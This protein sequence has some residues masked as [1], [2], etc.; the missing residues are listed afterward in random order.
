MNIFWLV[1]LFTTSILKLSTDLSKNNVNRVFSKRMKYFS[2]IISLF[3]LVA[4]SGLRS[5]IG[6]TGYYMYSYKNLTID[7]SSL[8][9]YRDFGF[10]VYQLVLKQFFHH[11][12][13]LIFITALI[14]LV[15]IFKT[16]NR[17]TISISFS[18]FLFITSGIYL[19]SMNGIRQF[20]AASIIFYATPI[21]FN[22]KMWKYILIVLIAST[23]HNSALIMIPVYFFA[24]I[25][26]S[27]KMVLFLLAVVTM[28]S[29]RFYDF[30]NIFSIIL[31]NTN[32]GLYIDSFGSISYDGA[33]FLRIAFSALPVILSLLYRKKLLQKLEYFNYYFNFT[34]LNFIFM[35]FASNNWLFARM[36]FYF[37]LYNLLLIPAILSICFANEERYTAYYITMCLFMIFFYF[38]IQPHD[39]ASYFLNINRNLIGPLTRTFYN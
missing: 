39:Y 34:V 24:K 23:I 6:D 28:V 29:V 16:I 21:M 14:T 7:F 22:R 38:D 36:G 18:V 35:I 11:P 19:S 2:I 9:S 27:Q 26:L 37:S 1:I 32:Y 20:L 13:A 8:L 30:F 17:Y 4:L 31:E 33:N 12:Q 5:S 25:E 10:I 3:I 15:L